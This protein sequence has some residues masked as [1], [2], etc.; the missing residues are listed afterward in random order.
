MEES[1]MKVEESRIEE[2]KIIT[3]NDKISLFS[4]YSHEEKELS[5]SDKAI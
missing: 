4:V 1:K 2:P 5:K 3:L